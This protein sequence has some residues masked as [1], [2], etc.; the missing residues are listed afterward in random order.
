V[1]IVQASRTKNGKG[2]SV[3]LEETGVDTGVFSGSVG[4]STLANDLIQRN[5][6]VADHDQLTVVY[7]DARGY[8]WTQSALWRLAE[9]GIGDLNTDDRIDLTDA[10]IAIQFMTG[11]SPNVQ[12][13]P[14]GMMDDKGRIS[15]REV[16]YI[17]QKTA[18]LR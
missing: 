15:I 11:T 17:L 14:L 9:A 8:P 16:I 3:I 18:G 12:V 5:I 7:T 4:F 10:V 6:L 2:F 13:N 1:V